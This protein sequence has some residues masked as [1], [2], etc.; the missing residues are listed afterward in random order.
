MGDPLLSPC[1]GCDGALNGGKSVCSPRCRT[2]RWRLQRDTRDREVRELLE[3]A[4]RRLG[5]GRP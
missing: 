5:E 1:R 2:R 4:L 3:A